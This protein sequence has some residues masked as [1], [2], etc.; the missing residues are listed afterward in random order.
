MNGVGSQY[1][2]DRGGLALCDI[3]SERVKSSEVK[4][5]EG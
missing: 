1:P 3:C 4:D 5:P 2:G